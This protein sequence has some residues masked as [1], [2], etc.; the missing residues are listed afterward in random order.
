[1]NAPSSS[2]PHSLEIAA[3]IDAVKAML[4]Q[5]SSPPASVKG[6]KEICVIQTQ[7]APSNELSNYKKINDANMKA[8]QNQINN[9]KNELRNEMQTLIQTSMSNQT[10]ELKNIMASLFQMN[11]ASSSG[12]SSLPS[13]TLANPRGDLKAI[14]T[15]SGISYDGP[16]IPPPFSSLS[17]VV[18]WEPE[19]T[20]DT[21]QP[22]TK[23]IQ[24][25]VVQIQA[26]IDEPVVAPK[27]K[28]ELHFELS[29][30]DAL[31]DMPKFASIYSYNDAVSIN[32][33]DVID[34]A[35]EEYAQ[36]VLG[37]FLD[38][39]Y[40]SGQSHSLSSLDPSFLL[41][42]PSLT[43]FKEGDFILE[44]IEACL[45]NDSIPPGINDDEFDPEGDLLL[46]E[47]LL[48]DDPSSP[49]PPKEL[50]VEE[51]KIVKSF[52][53][54]L[55]ALELKD[56]LLILIIKLLDVGL[57][58][59]I[60]DS[61]WVSLVHC[62]PKKGGITVIENDDNELIPTR[63]V[64]RW[65]VCIDY[66]KLN[67]ATRKDHFP[68]PFM[69]QMLER[70]AGN[71]YYCFL[72]G[73][74]GY[75]QIPIDPQDQD[76]TT[77][78]CP[79]G[80]FAYRRMPFGLCNAL[81][82]FQR[83]M[84]AIF[85]DMI[86]ETIESGIEVNKAKVDL[87]AK[88]PHLTSVKGIRSFL[89]H[90][91]FY[92]RF[93][94]DFSKIARPM[95]RLLEKDT[96]FF[97]SKECIELINILKKKLTEAPIL[98][99]PD[100]DL[101]FEIMC[102]ASDYAVGAVLGQRKTKNFH[103]MHYASK[104]MTDAQ[105]HHT[106]TEKELLAVVYAFEKFRPYLVL[107][108]T[109]VYTD[110]SALKYLLAK[111]DAKPRLLW[112][113][114]PLQ[115]FDVIIRD[116]KGAENLAA[117]HL[118]RL[119]IPH[120]DVLENKEITKIFLSRL[121]YILVAVD[122][123]SKWVEAKALPTNDARVV[124]KF[125][126]S[127]FAQFGTPH[128]IIS[129]PGTH[130]CND[131]FTKVML[132]YGV[133]GITHRLSTAY[134]P[135]TSGQVEV[136]NRGLKRILER[137][138]GENRTSWSDKLSDALWALCTTFKTPIGCTPYKLVYEKAC[139]LHIEL[140][141]KAYWALKHCN[142]DLKTAGDH[143]KVQMNE[144]N[145]L[146]DQ[147]YENSLIYKEKTKKIHDSKIKNRVFNVDRSPLLN[148]S[149]MVPSSYLKPTGQTSRIA[150]DFEASCACGFVLRS[151]ELQSLARLWESDKYGY[152]KN[153]KKTV[154]NEQ[155]RTR[156]SEEYKKKPKNQ[157]RS[158]K[159]QASVKSIIVYNDGLTSKSDLGIKPLINSECIDE[160]NLTDETSSFEYDEE[161][162]LRFNVLFN[163]IHPDDLKSGKDDDHNS[164]DIKQ[165]LDE[166]THGKMGFL[167]QVMIKS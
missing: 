95:T 14:T 60:F 76:K 82:T 31:L 80:T 104:T 19:V 67:D 122:Y 13:N 40:T 153:H 131:Q 73:F 155:A 68:L 22:S 26:P 116:K 72:D 32:Q 117:D 6:V 27:P 103:P 85:Y 39:L 74:S 1:M 132:K 150:P 160:F 143:R 87:I 154:K 90:A 42:S 110:H 97:F 125:L 50:H 3:L 52:I 120:Q 55:A 79:Y 165:S 86:E 64:T 94:Q 24:P 100:W 44:E 114:L 43:P 36:E 25:P 133:T 92:R 156:E 57:I 61:P 47:K 127:L 113:I 134:H 109:I 29:F 159:S 157:S 91:R 17:K 53:D 112:W 69:D 83:C 37:F 56:L 142:F 145:E 7:V 89:G 93:I 11:T 141:H 88:L 161:I 102:D 63:L 33:I 111:Q 62:V 138:I 38:K 108:K 115:E 23:N 167:K 164:I 144:L 54:D 10:N 18:E 151:L 139:H 126:E 49:L 21:V 106:T 41:S 15:Q 124:M 96:L 8:M 71:E 119:E 140:E 152:I 30:A 149:L 4:L 162:V 105:A 135:Q 20:K 34:V 121:L 137:T 84:M 148:F 51:L 2:T 9:V 136:S 59:P 129:D 12:T 46:L 99:A 78:T 35:C 81:G 65:R 107:S 130:F 48:N 118:S 147:A 58:Y 128:A 163:Y 98:V 166:I 146:R 75:F 70:L 5:K 101:P 123:L 66:R 16:P 28:P 45:T 158:Q 77:F